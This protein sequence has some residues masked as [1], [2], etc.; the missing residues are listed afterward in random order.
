MASCRPFPSSTGD[1]D[2]EFEADGDAGVDGSVEGDLVG[3]PPGR[4]VVVD[5][6]LGAPAAP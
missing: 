5:D 1:A 2:G 4:W 6:G 3:E